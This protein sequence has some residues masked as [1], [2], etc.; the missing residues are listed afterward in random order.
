MLFS[1]GSS[2]FLSDSLLFFEFFDS[3]ELVSLLVFSSFVFS[4]HS[5]FVRFGLRSQSL[6]QNSIGGLCVLF[7]VFQVEQNLVVEL[8]HKVTVERVGGWSSEDS[9][10]NHD[11]EGISLEEV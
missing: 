11:L 9:L 2:L 10:V 7:G 4:E 5:F 3:S 1:Q 6:V 8:R